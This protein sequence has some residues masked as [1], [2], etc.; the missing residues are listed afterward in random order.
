[1]GPRGDHALH[2]TSNNLHGLHCFGSL[3]GKLDPHPRPASYRVPILAEQICLPSLLQ[4]GRGPVEPRLQQGNRRV[5]LTPLG[6]K[7]TEGLWKE[8]K[9]DCNANRKF[10]FKEDHGRKY[11]HFLGQQK[12][13]SLFQNWF[14]QHFIYWKSIL[15]LLVLLIITWRIKSAR[16]IM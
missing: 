1:M 15:S 9:N 10:W 5:N 6:A 4:S 12:N 11:H 8:I 2:R 3:P 7:L 16:N 13:F 14:T